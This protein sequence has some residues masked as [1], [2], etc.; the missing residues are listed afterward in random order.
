MKLQ[1]SICVIL[2][3]SVLTM[4]CVQPSS[5]GNADNSDIAGAYPQSVVERGKYLVHAMGCDD[6]HS[7]KVMTP[8][9]PMPD[10]ERFLMAHPADEKL[11]E[12]TDKGMIAPGQWAL[13]NS[14]L[15]AAVGPWGTSFAAN[16]TPDDTGTGA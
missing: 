6:C 7:P 9:G 5:G 12:I 8:N 3:I 15:T 10:P 1:L 14:S 11:P 13:F 2:T 16:L 4:Q